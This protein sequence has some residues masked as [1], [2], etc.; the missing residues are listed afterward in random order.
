MVGMGRRRG[1]GERGG[2]GVRDE[3]REGERTD[4]ER[5][6]GGRRREINGCSLNNGCLG[7]QL[8]GLSSSVC[9][10]RQLTCLQRTGHVSV[11]AHTHLNTHSF[12]PL[13]PTV[14]I[15]PLF[16]VGLVRGC[17]SSRLPDC[18]SGQ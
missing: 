3:G 15:L 11:R 6:R 1:G 12:T 5:K 10:H 18:P 16:P 14:L 2:A 7:R 9:R 4:V 8:S 13:W 17:V